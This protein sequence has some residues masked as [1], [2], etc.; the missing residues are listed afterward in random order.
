METYSIEPYGAGHA[1]AAAELLADARLR[2]RQRCPLLP[3]GLS[4]A[5][6]AVLRL[7]ERGEGVVLARGDGGVAG[8]LFAER[9]EDETWGASVVSTV[10]MWMVRPD[11][12]AGALGALYGAGF[13]PVSR[14]TRE[15]RVFCPSFDGRSLRRWFQLGFGIEQAFAVARLADMDADFPTAGG[16]EIRRARAGDEDVLADVSPL[17]ALAQAGAPVWAGAPPAYLA[18]LQSGF[19]GLAADEEAIVLLGFLGGRPVGYQAWFPTTVD[20]IDGAFE[21]GVELSVAATVPGVRGMGVGRALTARG[22][23]EARAAGYSVCVTDWRTA[24]PLASAFWRA[25]G[26]EPFMYRLVRRFAE[27]L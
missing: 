16:L 20:A 23:A 11:A 3:P 25:R 27:P 13:E 2:R 18:D 19:R 17:I 14:G 9:R 4:D 12:G 8:F 22:V 15:H 6:T 24:N 1:G 10:D 5:S 7:E 21:G 26:F